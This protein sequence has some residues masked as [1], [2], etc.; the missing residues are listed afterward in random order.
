MFKGLKKILSKGIR[1]VWEQY[2]VKQKYQER[3]RYYKK[4][5]NRNCGPENYN[6]YNEKF[7]SRVQ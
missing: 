3:D 7:T 6:N 5:P 2:L 1:K 4:K